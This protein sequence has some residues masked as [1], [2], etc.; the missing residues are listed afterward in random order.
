MY[1]NFVW[2]P[3]AGIIVMNNI[4][5]A[6]ITHTITITVAMIVAI[7]FAIAIHLTITITISIMIPARGPQT[8]FSYIFC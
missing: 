1:E 3:R 2:G 7:T 5:M 4:I 8:K 6:V